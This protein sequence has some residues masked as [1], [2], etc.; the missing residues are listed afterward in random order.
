MDKNAAFV[1]V[2]IFKQLWMDDY[3]IFY[4]DAL[5]INSRSESRP[6]R[7]YNVNFNIN[8]LG[9]LDVPYTNI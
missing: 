8:Y 1:S 9:F 6:M 5:T 7:R 4:I 2:N 3:Y